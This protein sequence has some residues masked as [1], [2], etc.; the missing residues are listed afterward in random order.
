MK[1]IIS[2][3]EAR[4]FVDQITSDEL[5]K[6]VEQP[7]RLYAGFDPTA[8]SLHVGNL[9]GIVLL[10]WFQRFGH[11]P[12]ALVGGAT[13]LIGDP[14]GKSVERPL[15][16]R[17]SW[18]NNRKGIE[19]DLRAVLDKGHPP[20]F[21]DN[22]DWTEKLSALDLLRDVGRYFRMGPMLAKES[23]R[24]RIDSPEGMSYTEFSYQIL[25]AND[26]YHLFTQKKVVL[27][28]GGSDQWGNITAGCEL[29]R[30]KEGKTAYGLTFPL[31][32]R[33]DG[34]K[35]GK[36]E[37][38]AIW[39]SPEKLSPYE[40]YQYFIR[41]PDDDVI[42]MMKRLTFLEIEEIHRW[43]R[44]MGEEGYTP[45]T[46]QRRLAEA[47]TELV[48][49]EGALLKAIE[50]TR[51]VAPGAVTALDAA[52]LEGVPTFEMGRSTVVSR[53]MIDLLVEMKLATSK[54]EARRL[55][56]NGGIYLNNEKVENEE[57]QVESSDLIEGSF[58][59]LAV[60][61]KRKWAIR[62]ID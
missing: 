1:N 43:E 62:V 55:I 51:R 61:K 35:F 49:G 54:G 46:A 37:S 20:L 21:V 13:G 3:L 26:F 31:L 27:Q 45:N 7:I 33:S 60:G 28:I 9:V 36:S 16:D 53:P 40:F 4:G 10:A 2:A 30:K 19:R 42:T 11:H 58:L 15:L 59:L 29:I 38:G 47:V 48:H 14:S 25:Q 12:I 8:D 6:A 50:M 57:A 52:S 39:L 32:L 17:E 44:Q 34:K 22:L 24:L 18:L 5:R 41:V 56:R 23:V